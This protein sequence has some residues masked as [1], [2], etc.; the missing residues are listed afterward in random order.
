VAA[1][2]GGAGG[3][4]HARSGIAHWSTTAR[5]GTFPTPGKAIVRDRSQQNSFGMTLGFL[6]RYAGGAEKLLEV[7]VQGRAGGDAELVV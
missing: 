7:R 1:A 3:A 5:G 6:A 2:E 4:G